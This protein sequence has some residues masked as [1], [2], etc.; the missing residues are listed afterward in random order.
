MTKASHS[1][2]CWRC[3]GIGE[4][5]GVKCSECGGTGLVPYHLDQKQPQPDRRRTDATRGG[6]NTKHAVPNQHS[7]RAERC[8]TI[9]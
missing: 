8:T 2:P 5:G 9:S 3:K 6:D 7:C 4:V 1:E